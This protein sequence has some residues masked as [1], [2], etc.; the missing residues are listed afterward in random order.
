MQPLAQAGNLVLEGQGAFS[1]RCRLPAWAPVRVTCFSRTQTTRPDQHCL[2]PTILDG[3]GNEDFGVPFKGMEK[4]L[5]LEQG[6]FHLGLPR[7]ATVRTNCAD[8]IAG[9]PRLLVANVGTDA[10]GKQLSL[11]V[12]LALEMP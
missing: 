12:D 9:G 8:G 7:I 5:L 1:G 10:K 11:S 3:I 6:T 4:P 2:R